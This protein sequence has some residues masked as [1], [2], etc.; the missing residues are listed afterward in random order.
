[1]KRCLACGHT[2]PAED[3]DCAACGWRPSRAGDFDTYAPDLDG[4]AEGFRPEYFDQLA[5]LEATNFW[6]RVRNDLITLFVRRYF[7][8]TNNVLEVGC[9]TGFV[10]SA[11]AA[12][13]P[14]ARITGSEIYTRGLAFA[15]ARVPR[16]R[17]VQMDARDIPYRSE[18]DLIGA[19]D[20]VE[21]IEEDEVVLREM[22]AALHP[23]GGVLLTV[24]QH[25][26][27]WSQQDVAACHVRRYQPGELEA[28]LSRAGLRVLRST[29]FVSLLFPL[30]LASRMAK[31]NAP[32]GFDQ[33]SEFNIP[34]L[35]NRMLHSILRIEYHLIAGGLS[36]PF[37]GTRLVAAVKDTP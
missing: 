2:A 24:P 19:F 10:L 13:L 33:S 26:M 27:L 12:A 15:A 21:H 34:P 20:V 6:F 11:L 31:R 9:G 3:I 14:Q 30:L 18:F 8:G 28:K 4:T 7:P 5:A 35:L 37:G 17:L 22:A 25:R 16:A 1:M 36:F 23:G 29:S 32:E